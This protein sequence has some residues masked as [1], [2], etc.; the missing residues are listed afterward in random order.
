MK[1]SH[2]YLDEGIK[3]L[4]ARLDSSSKKLQNTNRNRPTQRRSLEG[5]SMSGSQIGMRRVVIV[6]VRQRVLKH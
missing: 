3:I 6:H 5:E 2:P 4:N 1:T